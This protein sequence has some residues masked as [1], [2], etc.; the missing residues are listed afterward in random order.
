MKE[1]VSL[2]ADAVRAKAPLVHCI[3]NYVTVNDCANIV[4]AFG[5]SPAMIDD[6]DEAAD[7]A[8]ISG[9]L[10]VNI[11]TLS[12]HQEAGILRAMLAAG[13]AGALN[14]KGTNRPSLTKGKAESASGTAC[15]GAKVPIVFDP[16]GC[17]AIP[18]RIA[19]LEYLHAVAPVSMIKGNMGE[20]MALA[21]MSAAVK[22]VD[23]DG[24]AEGIVDAARALAKKYSCVVAATGK[25]DVISDGTRTVRLK[26]GTELL[27]RITGAG[28]MA[29]ALC[30][31][32]AAAAS[33]TGSDMFIAAITGIS[34]MSIAGEIA[35]EKTRLPGSFRTALIDAISELDGRA[36]AARL[37]LDAGAC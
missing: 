13:A 10:Y 20:V 4:L 19:A 3:T 22:G 31:A 24:E 6:Y 37:L 33:A 34:A 30:A 17:G 7:F 26:N 8:A 1:K 9:S 25:S 2:L 11:G 29:G 16:V 27:T 21:G 35:A 15:G 5:G 23:S 32:T 28:C 12:R 14:P 36:I 18:K